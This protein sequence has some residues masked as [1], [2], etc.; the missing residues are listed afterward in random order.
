MSVTTT[1]DSSTISRR[2]L[3]YPG[4]L[5]LF[6][7]ASLT[8]VLSYTRYFI[9]APVSETSGHYWPGVLLWMSCFYPWVLLTPLVF[10]LEKRFPI[11]FERWPSNLSLLTL[12]GVVAVYTA[13][14]LSVMF[15]AGFNLLIRAP[16]SAL[17]PFWS[18]P[19]D[20]FWAHSLLFVGA[21]ALAYI[22]RK[23][24]QLQARERQSA[25]LALEKSQLESSLRRVE[26]D[27]LRMRLNPHFLFN[28]LQNIAVLTQH[29]PRTA[30]QM[31]VRLGDL[32][33]AAFRRDAQPE[34]SLAAEIALTQSYLEVERMRFQD[35]LSVQIE[36][37]PGTE[38][39]LVPA[40]LLQPLV[41][42]A[43]KHGL[44]GSQAVGNIMISSK[45]RAHS[46][47]LCVVDNGVGLPSRDPKQLKLGVGL[48]STAER[49]ALLYP[50]SHEFSVQ[51]APSGGVQVTVS[52]PFRSALLSVP[53]VAGHHDQPSPAHC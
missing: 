41:E 44:R 29:E 45:K 48:G 3:R 24:I 17:K 1:G 33:R 14:Q 8:G 27:V 37:E 30:S 34:V 50:G 47:L 26:L 4:L 35:R 42:N 21:V 5:G 28:T 25:A 11:G 16:V 2:T 32:L 51:E 53:P 7:L 9:F 36:I 43:M 49:L 12:G 23:L 40:L 39:A 20:E 31:L 15:A 10:R 13:F 52:F 46:L 6:L 22:V 19:F 18:I 38:E